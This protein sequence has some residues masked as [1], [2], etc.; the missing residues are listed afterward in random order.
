MASS[1]ISDQTFTLTPQNS[2]N[3]VEAVV[4]YDA[5]TKKATLDPS[6][7]LAWNTTY[8][9][10]IKGGSNGVKDQAGNTLAQGRSWTFTTKLP[11]EV[12]PSPLDF[13]P[14]FSTCNTTITKTVTIMNLNT[15]QVDVYPSVTNPHYSVASGVLHIPSGESLNLSINWTAPSSGFKIRDPGRLELRDAE[16]IIM[17]AGDLTAVINCGIDGG[18][19]L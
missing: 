19:P 10:T 5:T 11:V 7:D 13:T 3:P 17:G 6:S 9:A 8:T 4:S 2:T 15:S 1:S 18:L 16:G 14:G 12:T